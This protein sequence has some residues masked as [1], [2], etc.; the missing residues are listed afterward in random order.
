[1]KQQRYFIGCFIILSFIFFVIGCSPQLRHNVLSTLFDG[2]PEQNPGDSASV[3]KSQNIKR[4]KRNWGE[5]D[6]EVRQVQKED[7]AWS[8][9]LGPKSPRTSPQNVTPI[10]EIPDSLAVAQN[11]E[12]LYFKSTHPPFA[13]KDCNACHDA[14]RMGKFMR[15][16]PELCYQCHEDLSEKKQYAHGPAASGYCTSCHNPHRS[17]EETLLVSTGQELCLNCHEKKGI[18]QNKVHSGIGEKNCAECHNPHG[19]QTR[20]LLQPGLCVNCHETLEM[21]YDY[22]HGPVAG[23]HCDVCHMDHL[24][25]KEKLLV[26][27]DQKLCLNCH[28]DI[29]LTGTEKHKNMGSM[30]CTECHNPHGSNE[31]FMLK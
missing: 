8:A 1:M 14:G 20:H 7:G 29:N 4:N 24:S 23:E 3:A 25:G 17:K 31:R 18:L 11:K 22:V 12:S 2:V 9:V 26:R 16:Q 27:T 19:S 5:E 13:E 10:K 6:I 28:E 15:Q 30:F 21:S